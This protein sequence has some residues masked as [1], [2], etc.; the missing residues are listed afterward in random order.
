MKKPIFVMLV[1]SL[2]LA[3][4]TAGVEYQRGDVDQDGQVSIH[5][6]TFL[7]DYLLKGTWPDE[8]VTP[9][10]NHEFVDLGLPS[11]T[12]WATCNIG[13]NSPEEFGY[14]FAWGETEPKNVFQWENYK[15]YNNSTKKLTKYCTKSNYGTV[16]YKTVLDPEDDAAYVNW[17]PEWR[18]PSEQQLDE[19]KNKCTWTW[20]S[21]NGV[22]GQLVTGPNGNTI[23]LPAAN[24]GPMNM[25]GNVGSL[26][27]Y[28]S[29]TLDN[30]YPNMAAILHFD[31]ELEKNHVYGYRD[32]GY[33]VRAVCAQPDEEPD[34]YI[35]QTSIDLGEVPVGESRTGVLTIVNNTTTI[36]TMTATVDEP[37]MFKPG[38]YTTSS[39]SIVVPA[40]SRKSVTV[41]FEATT[42]GDFNGNVTFNFTGLNGG[43]L[44]VVP[45][46][47]TAYIDYEY[48]D[49]GLPS[50]TLWATCNIGA[51]SPEEYGDYFAWGE[52]EPK[53]VYNWSTYKWCNGSYDKLTKYNTV[54]SLG[55]VDNKTVLDPEDDA[56]FV[57][58]G[59]KWR[60][61]TTE[62]QKELI[63][64]CTW[65]IKTINGVKGRLVKG[66]NGN[67]IFLPPA[68]YRED[69]S[70]YNAGASCS[71]WSRSCFTSNGLSTKAYSAGN[72]GF[73]ASNVCYLNGPDDERYYGFSVRAVRA[74]QE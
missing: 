25:I 32:S 39:I 53:E 36:M 49:L 42:A 27:Y 57:N 9:P 37:F 20:T 55:T 62:Q 31:S 3:S 4:F 21:I 35:E 8:P 29:R 28:W 70:L 67:S 30:G 15:W 2:M 66:P 71:C 58:W 33:S 73:T 6:V 61:P 40:S 65:S 43:Q 50:G 22:N 12:L 38:E 69:G 44:C 34:L 7:I 45:V 24:Y 63:N 13:A 59:P 60:M 56:A 18:M 11:G 17:G 1:M 74:P 10:D 51:N 48:V 47:A 72:M 52:T 26:G 19:L 68:G 64:E 5:D 54:S 16:D 23:F 14:Y 41:I 46:H